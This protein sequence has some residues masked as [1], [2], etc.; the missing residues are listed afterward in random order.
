MRP[1]DIRLNQLLEIELQSGERLPSRIEENTAKYLYISMPI[2][3]AVLLPLAVGEDIRLIFRFKHA[4]FA[5][6]CRV[7]GRRREPIPCLI[8]NRP[9][10]LERINQKREYVRLE[11]NLPLRFRIISGG[12]QSEKQAFIEGVTFDLS[13]G[14]MLFTTAHPLQ[15]GQEIKIELDLPDLEP[16]FAMGRVVRVFEPR[17]KGETRRIAVE[18]VDISDAQKDRIFKYI[19]SKQREWIKRGIV[20]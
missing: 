2:R 20:D 13:A 19:F 5:C 3:Q 10:S 4:T 11:V 6:A 17:L 1:E 8:V 15:S 16:I 18:F 7:M 14:G 12:D 9:E